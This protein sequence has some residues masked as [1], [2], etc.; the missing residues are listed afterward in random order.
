MNAIKSVAKTNA[1]PSLMNAALWTL[2]G[3]VRAVTPRMRRMLAVFD[4]MTLPAATV[5]LPDNDA[6]TDVVSS[7]ADV[8][9][10]PERH[11]A[12]FLRP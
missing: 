9:K 3:A 4:P 11:A 12:S 8:P 1:A 5:A 10:P 7:G 6:E 2:I